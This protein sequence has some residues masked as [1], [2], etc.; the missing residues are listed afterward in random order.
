MPISSLNHSS[1]RAGAIGHAGGT[2]QGRTEWRARATAYRGT[3]LLFEMASGT[4]VAAL[5][6]VMAPGGALAFEV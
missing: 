5:A 4:F 2:R 6:R 1:T 3:S